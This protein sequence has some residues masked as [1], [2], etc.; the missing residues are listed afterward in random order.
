[1]T[2]SKSVALPL[3]DIPKYG[4]SDETRTRDTQSHNLVLYQLN[5][6]HHMVYLKGFEPLTHGLEGRCSIQLSY[7]HILRESL[8]IMRQGYSD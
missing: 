4:V 2:E 7:E 5:Y 1:M 8:A 6:A 3:G